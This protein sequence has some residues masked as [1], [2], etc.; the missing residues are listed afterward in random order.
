LGFLTF[1]GDGD[2]FLNTTQSD[3]DIE[4]T[5]ESPDFKTLPPTS[6]TKSDCNAAI[7]INDIDFNGGLIAF[8]LNAI[9]GALRN[10]IE[11]QMNIL[12]CDEA[13]AL[14]DLLEGL[15]VRLDELLGPYQGVLP[16][17][18][19]DRMYP[20]NNLEVPDDVQLIDLNGGGVMGTVLDFIDGFLGGTVEDPDSPTGTGRDLAI[21]QLMRS[22]LLDENRALVLD[23]STVLPNS[24][25]FDGEDM[26]TDSDVAITAVRIYGLDTMTEFR[27]LVAIGNYTISSSFDWQYVIV[28]IDLEVTIRPSNSSDAVLVGGQVPVVVEQ[29]QVE[30]GLEDIDIDFSIMMAIDSGHINDIPLG[31]LMS[32]DLLPACLVDTIYAIEVSEMSVSVG[33][34]NP[35]T[36]AG[37][38]SSGIDDLVTDASEALFALYEGALL[39]VMPNIFQVAIR[40]MFNNATEAILDAAGDCLLPNGDESTLLNFPDLLMTP[41]D[42]VTVGGSGT[43]PYGSLFQTVFNTIES[44]LTNDVG[45]GLSAINGMFIKNWT[46][47][48]SGIEGTLMFEPLV[49]I[50][51][52]FEV[53]G[54][55]AGFAFVVY[56]TEIENMDS[57]GLPMDLLSPIAPQLLNNIASIGVGPDPFIFKTKLMFG[58]DNYGTFSSSPHFIL[59][60]ILGWC[61]HLLIP[62]L[63]CNRRRRHPIEK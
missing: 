10:T 53:G 23:Q 24:T 34:I 37:F 42:A 2:L 17:E 25:I 9:E 49:D 19:A 62:F 4:I 55:Q 54:L 5:F 8:V 18:L 12:L 14:G 48:Q 61:E 57:I 45:Q 31:V 51:T 22:S 35:P 36:L 3:L 20:E 28:E 13:D 15:M 27:P 52:D 40:G 11:D 6:A 43:E 39:T 41:E 33:N 60:C 16:T 47:A 29:I 58:F 21:N 30:M 50:V 59:E 32:L 44:E 46:V 7:E 63:S 38:I 26:L 56:D 1:K